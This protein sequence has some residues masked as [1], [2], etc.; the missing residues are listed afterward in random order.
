MIHISLRI[1]LVSRE[2]NFL[3]LII[4]QILS[5]SGVVQREDRICSS[6]GEKF[7]S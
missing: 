5:R 6:N 2:W 3:R 7:V 4:G 1:I